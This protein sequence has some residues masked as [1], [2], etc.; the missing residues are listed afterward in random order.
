MK[1][2]HYLLLITLIGT[3][4]YAKEVSGTFKLNS[5]R[6]N[7]GN[8]FDA[9]ITVKYKIE[10]L[11]GEPVVK[12]TAK[13]EV[14]DAIDI[15]GKSY[16]KNKLSKEQLSKLKI[17][18]LVVSVPFDTTYTGQGTNTLYI[19]ISM[20]AMGKQGEWSFN[21]PDSPDW[22]KW[23]YVN[24]YQ[25]LDKNEAKKAYLGLK[26][27][28][29]GEGAY[30][31]LAQVK[32]IEYSVSKVA[33]KNIVKNTVKSSL[34]LLIDASGSMKGSKFKA[35][36]KAAIA[37]AK[38]AISQ[39]VEVSVAFFGG[40]CS[41]TNVLHVHDFTLDIDS[42]KSFIE[43]AYIMGGTPLS[44]ALKQ[45][46][47]YLYSHK[48]KNSKKETVLLLGDGEGNCGNIQHVI[49]ELKANHTFAHHETIGLEVGS[50]KKASVQLTNI[51]TQSGGDYHS[52]AS[53]E[54]L[55]RVFE[56]ASELEDL[57]NMVGAFGDNHH[58]QTKNKSNNSMQ[59]ILDNFE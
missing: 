15:D 57:D 27:L 35:A 59:S 37:N 34:M 33:I 1:L 7:S 32:K 12:A 44:L 30:D 10:S 41:D 55:E 21:P 3:T 2:L 47:E 26:K 49:N 54:E 14:G 20:G 43:N 38:K 52:S 8:S 19:D 22:D 28:G 16:P 46:N 51:A 13:Y 40:N 58:K 25:Y 42:L 5:F 36:K 39:N 24:G 56:D 53:V 29:Y 31:S 45:A 50:N 17:I 11:M 6:D 9:E 18:D 4:I 23:I 48:N